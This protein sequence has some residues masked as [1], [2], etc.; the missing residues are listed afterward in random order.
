DQRLAALD[1]LLADAQ[2][3]PL[4]RSGPSALAD[5]GRRGVNVAVHVQPDAARA[6]QVDGPGQ[7]RPVLPPDEPGE[8]PRLRLH[9]LDLR[10]GQRLREC[11]RFHDPSLCGLARC[12]MQRYPGSS[13]MSN[14]A[15]PT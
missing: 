7:G 12:Q 9:D 2:L 1:G 13:L 11:L 3:R 14:Q 5:V 6:L 10:T 15:T 4:A 8:P